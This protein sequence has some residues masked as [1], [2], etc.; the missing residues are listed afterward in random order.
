MVWV[1]PAAAT[2]S[3]VEPRFPAHVQVPVSFAS[4]GNGT[5]VAPPCVVTIALTLPEIF[6]KVKSMQRQHRLP[7]FCYYRVANERKPLFLDFDNFFLAELFYHLLSQHREVVFTEMLP[8]PE[9]LW[10]GGEDGR[11]C[12]EF[13]GTA[14]RMPAASAVEREPGAPQGV[15][16]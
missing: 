3:V 13:R 15:A 14:F 9:Q 5:D 11:L 1:T 4:P 8:A 2:D 10:F 6:V 16:A 7:R 12:A